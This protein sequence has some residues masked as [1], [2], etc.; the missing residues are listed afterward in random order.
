MASN[1]CDGIFVG[2]G[3]AFVVGVLEVLL[4]VRRELIQFLG[5]WILPSGI[6]VSVVQAWVTLLLELFRG[7]RCLTT[8]Q[9]R[10]HIVI[11]PRS[12]RAAICSGNA[13]REKYLGVMFVGGLD[14][15]DG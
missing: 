1:C 7:R 4:V 2:Q 6:S 10:P 9:Y 11:G 12:Q 15:I 3:G 14:A 13:G 8:G 5:T